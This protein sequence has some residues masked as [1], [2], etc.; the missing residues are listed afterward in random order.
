MISISREIEIDM[1]HRLPNHK[2][3][4]RNLHGHRYR[5]EIT[6]IGPICEHTGFSDEGM[7]VD[8]SVLKSILKEV[9]EDPYD[10]GFMVASQDPLAHSLSDL[11]GPQ[12]LK[13]II[14]PYI[15]TA[16]NMCAHIS[17]DLIRALTP[18]QLTLQSLKVWETPTSFAEYR[19]I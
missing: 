15:P 14:V 4:C 8:F 16:E 13:L 19:T 10:H 17:D 18:H 5:F 11:C 2:S 7:I 12:G 9:I 6:V 1:G 3:K